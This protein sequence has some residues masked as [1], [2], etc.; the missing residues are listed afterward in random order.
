MAFELEFV[1]ETVELFL[2]HRLRHD[3]AGAAHQVL[4]DGRLAAR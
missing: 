1:V 4:E 3:A 2:Q